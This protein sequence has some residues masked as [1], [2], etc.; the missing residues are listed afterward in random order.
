M[1]P[2]R[3]MLLTRCSQ[4]LPR[5]KN[6]VLGYNGLTISRISPHFPSALPWGFFALCPALSLTSQPTGVSCLTAS[7][8]LLNFNLQNDP[9][10]LALSARHPHHFCNAIEEISHPQFKPLPPYYRTRHDPLK[11][12]STRPDSEDQLSDELS[13]LQLS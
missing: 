13:M 4:I 8:F 1:L 2:S 9:S 10:G 12:N 3:S 5:H 6:T 7:F 11:T